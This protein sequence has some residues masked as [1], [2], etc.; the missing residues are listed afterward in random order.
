[1]NTERAKILRCSSRLVEIDRCEYF[2]PNTLGSNTFLVE[3]IYAPYLLPPDPCL[4]KEDVSATF[5]A[6]A[7]PNINV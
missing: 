4:S 5:E 6:S 2:P 7:P 3:G 1:M